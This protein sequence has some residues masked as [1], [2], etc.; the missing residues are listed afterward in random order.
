M[1]LCCAGPYRPYGYG[2]PPYGGMGM[3]PGYGMGMVGGPPIP[4]PIPPPGV[5]AGMWA[6][7]ND[8]SPN[9]HGTGY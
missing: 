7:N 6:Q 9:F 3:G 5:A 2:Y 4:P 1:G 8:W